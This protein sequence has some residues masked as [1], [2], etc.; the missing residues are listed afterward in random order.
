MLGA[1]LLL[2]LLGPSVHLDQWA[3]GVSPFTHIPRL[4]G[5]AFSA[6]PLVVLTALALAVATAGLA[7]LRHRNIG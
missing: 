1:G 2:W 6:L 3:M 5:S 4:P 7:G